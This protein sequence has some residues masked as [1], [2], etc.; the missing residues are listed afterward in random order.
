MACQARDHCSSPCFNI[1]GH[2]LDKTPGHFGRTETSGAFPALISS[3][4]NGTCLA[5]LTLC[6]LQNSQEYFTLRHLFAGFRT[7][8]L[9]SFVSPRTNKS[10]REEV[11]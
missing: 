9:E 2:G 5:K 1:C 7:L 8:T 4:N 11:C 6:R 3:I 10:R